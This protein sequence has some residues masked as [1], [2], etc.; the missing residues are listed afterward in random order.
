[1]AFDHQ[2]FR[3]RYRAAI[4]PDY[5]GWQHMLIVAL[6]GIGVIG[7]SV[8]QLQDVS[9]QQLLTVPLT[10]LVVNF[11]E[12]AAH[13]WAGHRKGKNPLA[14][15]FYSRHTGDHHS[16]FIESAMPFESTRDWRVVLFPA[17]LIFAFLFGL[18]APVWY[19]LM[20][21]G[22]GN[23]AYLYAASAIGGYLFYEGMHFSYHLPRGS[24]VEKTPGWKQLRRLHVLHHERDQMAAKNFNITLPI[25]DLLLNT[26]YWRSESSDT[27]APRKAESQ[28]D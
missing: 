16:F 12:Y 6:T 15:L 17:Y 20:E 25:F 22:H 27:S 24:F 19:L 3:Q 11:A 5:R 28:H 7:Y 13:R 2:Q 18:V 21:M 26:L 14:R 23:V 4:R 9:W 10:L 1:M 8:A